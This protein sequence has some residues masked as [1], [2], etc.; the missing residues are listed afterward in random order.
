[1]KNPLPHLRELLANTERRSARAIAS[2]LAAPSIRHHQRL[3]A[4]RLQLHNHSE[5]LDALFNL[6]LTRLAA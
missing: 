4:R 5:F 1:M 2:C 6:H 3:M